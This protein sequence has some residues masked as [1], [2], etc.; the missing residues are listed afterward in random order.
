MFLD[1]FEPGAD[2]EEGF[3][4]AEVEDYD[5]TI[6]SLVIGVRDRSISLLTR[7]IPLE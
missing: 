1:L 7:S 6:C 3:F 2:V 4:V 5:Y